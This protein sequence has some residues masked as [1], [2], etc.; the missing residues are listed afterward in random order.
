MTSSS[1]ATPVD[2]TEPTKPSLEMPPALREA[3]KDLYAV[4]TG[5][6]LGSLAESIDEGRYSAGLGIRRGELDKLVRDDEGKISIDKVNDLAAK[7]DPSTGVYTGVRGPM[8]RMAGVRETDITKMLGNA[9][10][11]IREQTPE[12]RKAVTLFPKTG[13]GKLSQL[14]SAEEIRDRVGANKKRNELLDNL[15]TTVGGRTALTEARAGL[16][17]GATLNNR[18]LQSLLTETDEQK[19]KTQLERKGAQTQIDRGKAEIKSLGDATKLA[20]GR[21][22]LDKKNSEADIQIRQDSNGIT[23]TVAENDLEIATT[24]LEIEKARLAGD[25]TRQQQ[26]LDHQTQ[27]SNNNIDLQ[28]ALAQINSNDKQAD[29][30][31]DRERE[32][33]DRR[34]ALMVMLMQ[35]LGNLGRSF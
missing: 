21:L 14:T 30:E 24:K 12:Y 22:A 23:R 18:Q 9:Y 6:K 5:S 13:P 29:R 20:Q 11:Q 26:L 8:M 28:K 10:Q 4:P 27:L 19:P 35:G 7:F 31:Y 34:Q 1:P 33:R 3:L 25:T 2:L 16:T 32:N 17:K 15:N